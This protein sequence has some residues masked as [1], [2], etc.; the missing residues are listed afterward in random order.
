VIF[1]DM[2]D[3]VHARVNYASRAINALTRTFKVEVN[4]DNKKEYHPNMVAKLKINDYKSPKP[5][6][7]LPEKYIQKSSDGKFVYVAENGMVVK[8]TITTARE[9]SGLAEIGSG[10][11]EGEM[12]ITDGYDQVNEGDKIRTRKQV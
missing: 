8:R 5:V 6:L 7:V 11:K 2:K 3:S 12:V 4:L 10:L 9:Y 1:P